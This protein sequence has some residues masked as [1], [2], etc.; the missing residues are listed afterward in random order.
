MISGVVDLH[1]LMGPTP[2][3]VMRQYT[4]LEGRPAMPPL[5]SLGFHQCRCAL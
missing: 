4:A 5:W 2:T 1:F 3:D